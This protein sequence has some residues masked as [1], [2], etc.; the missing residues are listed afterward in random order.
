MATENSVVCVYNTHLDAEQAVKTLQ[1]SG[2]NMKQLSI[3][4][5]DYHTDEHPVG[6]WHT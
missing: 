3:V 4:G 1:T 2:F 5:K 6:Y